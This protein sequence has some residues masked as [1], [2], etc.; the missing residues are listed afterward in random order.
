[1]LKTATDT[2]G[3]QRHTVYVFPSLELRSTVFNGTATPNEYQRDATTEVGYLFANGVRLARLVNEPLDSANTTQGLRV[4]IELGDYLGS[5]SIAIDRATSELAE[6]TT[7][8]AYGGAESDYRPDKWGSF[9]EDY[10]FTGKEEDVEV[11]LTYF[12]KRFYNASLQRWVSADPLEVHAPG[13]ADANLYAYVSGRA[14][15]NIDPL[16]LQDAEADDSDWVSVPDP[17]ANGACVNEPATSAPSPGS[18]RTGASK[19]GSGS[20]V[21][22]ALA[23]GPFALDVAAKTLSS[24]TEV[25]VWARSAQAARTVAA[26]GWMAVGL[27]LSGDSSD[28]TNQSPIGQAAEHQAVPAPLPEAGGAGKQP[29]VVP[30]VALAEPEEPAS[31]SPSQPGPRTFTSTDPLVG[32]LANAIERAHPGL[33]VGVNVP[34][35]NTAGELVT[36]ADIMLR[37]A[38]IQ[39]KSGG[40][41]GLTNQLMRTQAATD[42]PVIGYGPQ[43]RS[44][45]VRGIEKAGGLVTRDREFLIDVVA[46]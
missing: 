9:R 29:P 16:G 23:P 27:I 42:L 20:D 15:R 46:P 17:C 1:V 5:Q 35:R 6:R 39:V 45:V 11:G 41:K 12:D 31:G 43:L 34:I 13:E 33:V 18:E 19:E 26:L 44:S 37:N 8:Q 28:I 24:T 40:G 32:E 3:A 25:G 4:F 36:D 14:L 38:V 2:A 21:T 30:P 10:G 7:Y 22:L